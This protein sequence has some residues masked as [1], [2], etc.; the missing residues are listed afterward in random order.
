MKL[1]LSQIEDSLRFS[2]SDYLYNS[3]VKNNFYVELEIVF[4][5]NF[6]VKIKSLSSFG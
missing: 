5:S 1:S 4:E 2:V 3:R 6:F